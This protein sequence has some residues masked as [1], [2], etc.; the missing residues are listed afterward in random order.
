MKKNILMNAMEQVSD[1]FIVE[2]SPMNAAPMTR[3]RRRLAVKWTSM[4]AGVCAALLLVW[5]VVIPMIRY[6]S[7]PPVPEFQDPQFT[8]EELGEFFHLAYLD[9]TG[10]S[11]YTK[12]YVPDAEYLYAT[13]VPDTESIDIFERAPISKP[14]D[15]EEFD[16]FFKGI[17]KRLQN[18]TGAQLP[19]VT[20][21]EEDGDSLR[22]SVHNDD[23]Y[24][25]EMGEFRLSIRQSLTSNSCS[26]RQVNREHKMLIN[27][28]P[29]EVDQ[30]L[31]DAEIKESLKPLQAQLNTLFGVSFTDVKIIR[32]YGNGYGKH[33]VHTMR[34][35]FY[36]ASDDPLNV[37]S[38]YKPIS[39][40][41]AL[42]F[43]N[44]P[45]YAGDIVSDKILSVVDVDYIQ[46]RG[47]TP[48]A[49][50]KQVRLIS[51]EEAEALLYNGYVFG[52]HSCRLCMAAQS[53]VDF[54]GYDYVG[55]SYISGDQRE[56]GSCLVIPFYTFYKKIGTAENRSTIYA[57]TYV[58]AIEAKG[59]QAYFDSQREQHGE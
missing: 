53:K 12:V 26:L 15:T 47:K 7:L 46:Y 17:L 13:P 4:A 11:S 25:F 20:V 43:D 32:D 51:L 54:E 37:Y 2:A 18:A 5:Q 44:A 16:A 31:S 42:C 56:D 8:A 59:Y 19:P 23:A 38:T 27:G 30:T 58:A 21:I 28:I 41:I 50:V 39:D 40:F 24:R 57:K 1:E 45:N 36:D 49:P 22:V 29:V 35:Y 10:T 48:S 6:A 55:L 14:I 34:I 3:I 9:G 52:G 33:G